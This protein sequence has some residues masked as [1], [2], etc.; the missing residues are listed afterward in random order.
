LLH[1]EQKIG[2]RTVR[3]W[4]QKFDKD[5]PS[6][7]REGTAVNMFFTRVPEIVS[8]S[9]NQQGVL[10]EVLRVYDQWFARPITTVYDVAGVYEKLSE[11]EQKGVRE[12]N[13]NEF[14]AKYSSMSN[15]QQKG[16]SAGTG[17]QQ[18]PAQKTIRLPLLKAMSEYRHLSEQLLTNEKIK[19]KT[20]MEPVRPSLGNWL[21]SYREEIGIGFHETAQRG[22]FL[23]QSVNCKRL[24]NDDRARLNL[25][26][27]SVEE[28]FPLEI[29]TTHETIIFP[30]TDDASMELAQ[31]K[32]QPMNRTIRPR[33]L[34]ANPAVAAPNIQPTTPTVP[35]AVKSQPAPT[36]KPLFGKSAAPEKNVSGETLHFSTG[37]VLP[38]ERE[39]DTAQTG[40]N[41][42]LRQMQQPTQGIRR[43]PKAP[44]S[45]SPYSIRPLRARNGGNGD[46]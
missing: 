37:H 3:D 5:F 28:D 25:I 31:V 21:R 24:S 40:V 30:R 32:T 27:K 20:S 34:P 39:V 36:F 6:M 16:V 43:E 1:N 18:A 15:S 29:D 11:L 2:Q 22:N 42:A 44:L 38:A 10:R 8:M 26:L 33:G 7:E 17:R 12:V 4:V 35:L 14:R 45:K 13:P 23:F 19:L 46:I 9:K 41:E